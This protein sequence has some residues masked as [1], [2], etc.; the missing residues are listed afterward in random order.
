MLPLNLRKKQFSASEH[1]FNVNELA[2]NVNLHECIFDV[3]VGSGCYYGNWSLLATHHPAST[4]SEVPPGKFHIFQHHSPSNSFTL[5]KSL[6]T[7]SSPSW[8][9][10]Y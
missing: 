8:T 10:R 4:L 9:Q 6:H 5:T 3:A 7:D 1:A 2:N